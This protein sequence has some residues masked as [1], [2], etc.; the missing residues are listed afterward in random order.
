MINKPADNRSVHTDALASLGMIH[1]RQE[2]R[3]AIHLAVEPVEA[4]V[5]L[6]PGTHVYLNEGKAYPIYGRLKTPMEA[7]ALGIVDPFITGDIEKGQKFWLVVYPREITSLRH[8]WEHPSFPA[9]PTS[10]QEP[11]YSSELTALVKQKHDMTTDDRKQKAYEWIVDYATRL[12]EDADGEYNKFITA[13]DL[14]SYGI[15]H[16]ADAKKGRWADS[17]VRGGTLEGISTSDEFWDQLEIY[18]DEPIDEEFRGN[19]FSC[20]C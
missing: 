1:T 14:I 7:K 13:A 4:G 5:K 16:V 9:V 17:L 20:S 10:T 8:V 12:S 19:F 18:T 11:D 15:D 3:D 2:Y 6:K